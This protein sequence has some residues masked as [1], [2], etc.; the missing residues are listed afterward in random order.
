MGVG[1][2]TYQ[3]A[4]QFEAPTLKLN[5]SPTVRVEGFELGELTA[6][7]VMN[8]NGELRGNWETSIGSGGPFHLFPNA[9]SEPLPHGQ[10]A[11]QLHSARYTFAAIAIERDQITEIAKR[12]EREFT[13]AVVTIIDGT[14]RSFHLRDFIDNPL[15]SDRVESI[16]LFARKP[17]R[18]ELDQTIPVEFGP[19]YNYAMTQGT[20]EAWVLGQLETLKR[21]IKHFER[22]Y[23]TNFKKFGVS[24]ASIVA[25]VAVAFL[26]NLDNFVQRLAFCGVVAI[27]LATVNWANVRLLPYAVINLGKTKKGI[28]QKSWPQVLSAFMALVTAFLST[29]F[30]F[31][32]EGGFK[33]SGT[34]SQPTVVAP[35]P[36]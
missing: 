15:T 28:W 8:A 23:F 16:R 29:L 32:L 13:S 10:T 36:K 7:G 34:T 4:G 14:E 3:V 22:S 5:G 25:I 17:D 9:E 33:A 20:N 19:N 35:L 26:P 2:A 31:Y 18:F 12:I 1:I 11:E 27:L 21:D 30:G 6:V 24:F